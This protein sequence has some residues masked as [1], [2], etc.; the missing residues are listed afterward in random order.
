M[1]TKFLLFLWT[2]TP[3]LYKQLKG[4]MYFHHVPLVAVK[5]TVRLA[6]TRPYFFFSRCLFGAID[7]SGFRVNF[8]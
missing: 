7:R 2:L 8:K 3:K 5:V 6:K 4:G 1:L